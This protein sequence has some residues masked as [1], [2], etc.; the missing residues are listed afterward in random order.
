MIQ[1]DGLATYSLYIDPEPRPRMVAS[2]LLQIKSSVVG[3]AM[4]NYDAIVII[5]VPR[6]LGS[7]LICVSFQIVLA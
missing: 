4:T 1:V 7:Q 5:E 2:S 3:T 6:S